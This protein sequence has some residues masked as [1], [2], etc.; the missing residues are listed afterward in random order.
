[1]PARQSAMMMMPAS[2]VSK[3]WGGPHS[4][5]ERSSV[6]TLLEVHNAC[7]DFTV[8]PLYCVGALGF[9]AARVFALGCFPI[10]AYFRCCIVNR[11]RF[12]ETPSQRSSASQLTRPRV[13]GSMQRRGVFK[14]LKKNEFSGTA[15]HICKLLLVRAGISKQNFVQHTENPIWSK[16]L[17]R[18]VPA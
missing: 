16:C 14:I 7:S 17:S 12:S 13:Y 5:G 15:L 2:C 4:E 6:S 10:E 8:S 3:R 1:M 11:I 9:Y 18:V